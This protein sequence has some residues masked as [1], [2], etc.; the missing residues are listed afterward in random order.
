MS[1]L[2]SM[3]SA[4][5]IKDL[6]NYSSYRFNIFGEFI[7][8]FILIFFIYYLSRVFLNTNSSYLEMFNGNY[9]LFLL[10]GL[11]LLTFTTRNFSAIPFFISTSQSQGYFEKLLISKT[12]ITSILLASCL[13]PIS[14]SIF[15]IFI[16][17]FFSYVF[18][19][20][21]LSIINF[22]EM[23]I[24]LVITSIPFIGL[25]LVL[26]SLIIIYKK[27]TF[28]NSL[29]LLGCSIFSGIFYPVQVMPTFFQYISYIFPTTFSIDLIR[30]R[31][32]QETP[33]N[34]LYD[35]ILLLII[36]S[37]TYVILGIYC[38][39]IAI[40]KVKKDGSASHF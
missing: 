19:E 16:I 26:S 8:G 10:T 2:L 5:Y 21:T 3:L 35:N 25:S 9:F 14:Q 36:L 34:E 32:L 4:T 11:S 31:V 7:L 1:N 23:I 6:K 13:F 30:L 38:I 39:R 33:F 20:E 18:S 27:A 24:L 22:L 40:A 15:R 37:I 28:L 17:Y 29:F 12:S